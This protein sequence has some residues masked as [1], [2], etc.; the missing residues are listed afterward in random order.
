M[1]RATVPRGTVMPHTSRGI[2]LN[3]GEMSEKLEKIKNLCVLSSRR[4]FL[5]F[6]HQKISL[7]RFWD[8]HRFLPLPV[9]QFSHFFQISTTN[10]KDH[11]LRLNSF[12][13][14]PFEKWLE[15]AHGARANIV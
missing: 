1:H 6:S 10:P 5:L 11:L 9:S 7:K 8:Q 13:P 15:F 3:S 12:R 2:S 4:H 14:G